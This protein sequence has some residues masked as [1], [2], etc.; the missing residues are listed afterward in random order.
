[1]FLCPIMTHGV[2]FCLILIKRTF[3]SKYLR[4]Y[5]EYCIR[6]WHGHFESCTGER[7]HQNLHSGLASCFLESLWSTRQSLRASMLWHFTIH[8]AAH[9]LSAPH[10]T[11]RK[12]YD[13]KIKIIRR[14]TR[15]R[16]KRKSSLSCTNT[17]HVVTNCSLECKISNRMKFF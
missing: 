2:T 11:L 3:D 5:S 17:G 6:R 14:K 7:F 4:F 10:C 1:M 8:H 13:K 9:K 16:S 15:W 12:I